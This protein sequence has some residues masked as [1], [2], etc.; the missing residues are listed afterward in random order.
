MS[1]KSLVVLFKTIAP[2]ALGAYLFWLFF[3]SMTDD[4]LA[5]F[6]K[7]FSEANYFWVVLSL[8]LAYVALWSRATRWKY[9]LEALDYKT[10]YSN[11]YHAIMIGYLVNFTI[12]RAGE[13]SRAAMLYRSDG[14]P[15]S[16]SFGTII[17]ERVFD[18]IMLGSVTGLAMLVGYTDLM[19]IFDSISNLGTP[20]ESTDG[21]STKQMILIILGALFLCVVVLIIWKKGLRDKLIHFVKDVIHGALSIFKSKNPGGFIA[22]TL[23]IWLCY[24]GMFAVPFYAL[25][26]TSHFP[27]SGL[28]IGFIAGSVGITLTNGG[29]GVYPI[30]VGLVVAFYIKDDY[31]DDAEG[32]G[33]ALGMLMWISQ[34]LFM[35][36]LGLVSL[37]LL[38]K[39][40][41]KENDTIRESSKQNR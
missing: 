7:A 2:L 11:R 26:E 37:A 34:T 24:I 8:V 14:V 23:L 35:V 40:Y 19:E 36:I 3:S 41:T 20:A 29:L 6:K 18:L 21:V 22:H 31:P 5:S 4:D 27:M 12:P 28:L 38:P 1:K 9:M 16:K 33:K 32:I 25:P 39:N 13:A 17:G 15:F 30:L 10:P